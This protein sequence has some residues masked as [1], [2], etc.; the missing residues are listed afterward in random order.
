MHFSFFLFS[1]RACGGHKHWSLPYVHLERVWRPRERWRPPLTNG[2]SKLQ[3]F[4]S[5]S[6]KVI[7]LTLSTRLVDGYRRPGSNSTEE[8]VVSS[9]ISGFF[10]L[11]TRKANRATSRGMAIQHD[12]CLSPRGLVRAVKAQSL[13]SQFAVTSCLAWY[14]FPSLPRCAGRRCS[15]ME[16]RLTPCRP[17]KY[18]LLLHQLESAGRE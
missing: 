15:N 16:A 7:S 17:A 5:H 18:A 11:P 2:T 12:T 6:H 13:R 8:F 4:L 3:M 1:N 9:S 14:P 10:A